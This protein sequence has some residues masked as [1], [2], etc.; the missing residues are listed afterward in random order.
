MKKIFGIMSVTFLLMI[1]A[2]NTSN[3]Q[4]I[5]LSVSTT[6]VVRYWDGYTLYIYSNDSNGAIDLICSPNVSGYKYVWSVQGYNGTPCQ[7]YPNL[8]N[9]PFARVYIWM[10]SAYQYGYVDVSCEVYNSSG[11]KLGTAYYGI[12]LMYF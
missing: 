1:A 10:P 12:P 11:T 8:T 5:S 3:A 7:I 9:S 4:S 6:S 2:A